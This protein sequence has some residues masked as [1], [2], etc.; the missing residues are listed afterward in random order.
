MVKLIFYLHQEDESDTG[1]TPAGTLPEL[2]DGLPQSVQLLDIQLS[3][4]VKASLIPYEWSSV[5]DAIRRRPQLLYVGIAI[6]SYSCPSGT[7]LSLKEQLNSLLHY[8]K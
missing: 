5:C 6:R 2:I 7:E 4:V 8:L 1:A 3:I